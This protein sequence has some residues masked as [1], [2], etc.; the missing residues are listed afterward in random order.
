MRVFVCNFIYRFFFDCL[1]IPTLYMCVCVL[2]IIWCCDEGVDGM[3]ESSGCLFFLF[4]SGRGVGCGVQTKNHTNLVRLFAHTRIHL[5]LI[6]DVFALKHGNT[7]LSSLWQD[8]KTTRNKRRSKYFLDTEEERN[9][10]THS[11]LG[12]SRC[13][14]KHT[15]THINKQQTFVVAA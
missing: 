3:G 12:G 1:W 2:W 9:I 6:P 4:G 5:L 15:H 7:P 11:L 8:E 10:G 13:I 14:Y